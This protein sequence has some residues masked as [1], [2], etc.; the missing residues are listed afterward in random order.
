[1]SFHDSSSNGTRPEA[2]GGLE[3]L[4]KTMRADS[5]APRTKVKVFGGWD[6]DDEETN[7]EEI[8][9]NNSTAIARPTTHTAPTAHR[10]HQVTVSSSMDYSGSSSNSNSSIDE[11]PPFSVRIK[12]ICLFLTAGFFASAGA[13]FIPDVFTQ[14]GPGD[15]TYGAVFFT[16]GSCCFLT[17]TI[18]DFIP[19]LGQDSAVATANAGLFV[20]VAIFLVIGSIHFFPNIYDPEMPIGNWMYMTA[21]TTLFGA[22]LWTIGRLMADGAKVPLPVISALFSA[23]IGAVLYNIG[24]LI[25]FPTYIINDQALEKGGEFFIVGGCFLFLHALSVYVATYHWKEDDDDKSSKEQNSHAAMTN[26]QRRS[27]N[28][29]DHESDTFS[30]SSWILLGGYMGL[31]FVGIILAIV[32]PQTINNSAT[33]D[34][35][36][37]TG[38]TDGHVPPPISNAPLSIPFSTEFDGAV[39]AMSN[40][41]EGNTVLVYG[42]D[43]DG[44]LTFL[45]EA[46]TGGNGGIFTGLEGINPLISAYALHLT[47]EVDGRRFVLAVNAGSNSITSFLVNS[48]YTLSQKDIA[49]T[50]GIGPNSITYHN[51]KV[52]VTNIGTDGTD[53]GNICRTQGSL[54]GFELSPSGLLIEIPESTRTLGYRPA[55]IQFTPNGKHLVVANW[56][57]GCE[58]LGN[59]EISV[60]SVLDDTNAFRISKESTA[61]AASTLPDNSEGRNLGTAIGLTTVQ[62]E[63]GDIYVVVTEP[64][65]Y[66]A[67]GNVFLQTGSVST[68]RLLE[69]TNDVILEPI[70][71]DVRIGSDDITGGERTACW[72]QFTTDQNFFFVTNTVD[73]SITSF[74]FQDGEIE[75]ANPVAY[76]GQ[77]PRED[78]LLGTTDGFIDLSISRDGRYIYVLYG[79]VGRIGVFEVNGSNLEI[80]EETNE[81]LP[82]NNVQG[83][84]SF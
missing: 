83:I 57:A 21:T 39:Y 23:L 11:S 25:L 50:R 24:T 31:I 76:E 49:L 15:F 44:T 78:D 5:P 22:L 43:S 34:V 62:E 3:P 14:Y 29:P 40:L 66:D 13:F 26:E 82:P 81:N 37:Q 46:Q 16:V 7:L 38:V 51:G 63:N 45:Q 65:E 58:G 30:G 48:D 47:P 2:S 60:F 56:N 72:L 67:E 68:W 71:L 84:V 52:F 9:I 70:D 33:T 10:N 64:R 74:R 55:S 41:L 36:P 54:I 1:M 12:C 77:Q 61:G 73:S 80:I 18:I 53:L 59:D 79:L 8:K 35:S 19:T 69:D 27:D 28:H 4:R 75:I 20:I 6:D 17:A 42:R 32:L